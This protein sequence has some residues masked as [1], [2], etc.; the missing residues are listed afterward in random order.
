[1]ESDHFQRYDY[2]R[3]I[4]LKKYGST[5]PPNYPLHRI[6]APVAL[7]YG[8]NDFFAPVDGVQKLANELSNLIGMYNIN[9][10]EFN[11][12]NFIDAY[13]VRDLVYENILQIMKKYERK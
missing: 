6:V 11:H 13:N 5:D 10:T 2:G 9:D 4:N 8:S 1:M 12:I 7:H 3:T